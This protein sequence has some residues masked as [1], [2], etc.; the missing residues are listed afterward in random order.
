MCRWILRF[1]GMIAAMFVVGFASF[2]QSTNPTGAIG[3]ST[4]PTGAVGP[5]TSAPR[6]SAPALITR[7][8]VATGTGGSASS[9]TVTLPGGG[10]AVARPNGNGTTTVTHTDGTTEVVNT[11]R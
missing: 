3:L 4:N 5:P 1:L 2:A 7:E 11:P 9:Q 8:G 6:P 10:I